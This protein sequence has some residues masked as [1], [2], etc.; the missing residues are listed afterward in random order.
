MYEAMLISIH[1]L[2]PNFVYVISKT[3]TDNCLNL[4]DKLSLF[5]ELKMAH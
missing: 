4:A 5:A 1:S 3:D 2:L